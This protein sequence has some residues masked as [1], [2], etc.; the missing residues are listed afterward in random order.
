MG[1]NQ[2]R[3]QPIEN[4]RK[5]LTPRPAK[6][7]MSKPKLRQPSSAH[8]PPALPFQIPPPCHASMMEIQ[9]Y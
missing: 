8:L 7:T 3:N 9:F 6:G 2:Q 5:L 1:W 4:Q